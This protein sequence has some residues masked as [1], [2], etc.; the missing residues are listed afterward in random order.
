MR[1]LLALGAL[2]L[3]AQI[4]QPTDV[5]A[6]LNAQAQDLLRQRRAT[7]AAIQTPA[8]ARERQAWV[9]A[10]LLD[11][12]TGLPDYK[13]PLNSRTTGVV[14]QP[15][16]RIEKVIFESL[17][18]F[19][20]TGNLYLPQAAGRHPAILFSMGH[21]NEGKPVAQLLAGNLALQ[22]FVVL[23]YD[24]IGQGERLQGFD[25]VTRVARA[26]GS[27][28]QHF[29]AG[30]AAILA[31]DNFA[32]YMIHDSMRAIDHLQSRPEVDPEKIGATGCSGGGTQTSFVA[33]I[34][35]R[36]KVAAPA[37]YMQ[38]FEV[39]FPGDIGDSEQS[40]PGFI[41]AGLDQKDFVE[42]FAPKPWLIAS[43][44]GDFFKPAG[45]QAVFEEAKRVYKLLDAE[46]QVSWAVGPGPHGTP[47]EVRQA[48]YG[49]FGRWLLANPAPKPEVAVKVLPDHELW[50]TKT[51]QVST[52]L[53]A[54]DV[55]E[56]IRERWESRA[57]TSERPKP[58][59]TPTTPP[60]MRSMREATEE[61]LRVKYQLLESEAGMWVA[62]RLIEPSE[63]S[64]KAVLMLE[65]A[66]L[67]MTLAR[68][69]YRV[70]TLR[71]RGVGPG[72]PDWIRNG[73][74]FYPNT[75][76]WFINPARP[77]AEQRAYDVRRAVDYLASFGV[78]DLRASA[79][80]VPG[81]WLLR[82]AADDL[83]LKRIWLDRTPATYCQVIGTAVHRDLHEATAPGA[84]LKA[85]WATLRD[86]RTLWSD[87]TDWL[88][89]VQGGLPGFAYRHFEQGDG[90]LL[91]RFLE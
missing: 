48:I 30:A 4:D 81:Y 91:K 84:C 83:R 68:Q 57:K 58:I 78:T 19:P 62:T 11:L 71:P 21:W 86:A 63:P 51:G 46:A 1:F 69:G 60:R 23:V 75:R 43:T 22:G 24:P 88:R 15:G 29:M 82:A 17:P 45:A 37:C 42:V 53:G 35:P 61:G 9:R 49:W 70:L 79:S 52:D 54:R 31:G 56:I 7:V 6:W 28:E 90:D 47:L 39:L 41:G 2:P 65:P 18:K 12:L 76:A 36:V 8:Q 74:D 59:T 64:T 67:A 33:A 72:V 73:G 38:S 34:D 27:V 3:L 89:Q 85:D 5:T 55:T 50:A 87:P 66:P 14:Q 16:Y 13:G 44:E 26:G 32:R 25:P 77:M 80:G 10:K 40:W 20:I